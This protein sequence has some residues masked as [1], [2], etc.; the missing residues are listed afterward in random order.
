MEQYGKMN[1]FYKRVTGS[2]VWKL[3]KREMH[4]TKQMPI[5]NI[6]KSLNEILIVFNCSNKKPLKNRFYQ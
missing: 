5:T 4:F 1:S 3:G 2:K 6:D